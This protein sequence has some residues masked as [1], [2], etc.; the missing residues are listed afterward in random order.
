MSGL[1]KITDKNGLITFINKRI[2]EKHSQ[3]KQIEEEK[4]I[5][6]IYVTM[7]NLCGNKCLSNFKS[8]TLSVNEEICLTECSR[9]YYDTLSSGNGLV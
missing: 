1:E 2:T 7:S 8:S 3:S 4:N 9:K 6:R 5:N